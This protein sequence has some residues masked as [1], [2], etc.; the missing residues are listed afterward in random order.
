MGAAGNDRERLHR[1]I[2]DLHG[3]DSRW[4]E[5]VPVTETFEGQTIWD[6]VVQVF[7]LIDHP[8]ATRAYAWS[9]LWDH[10]TRIAAGLPDREP[11][12]SNIR[13]PKR[14]VGEWVRLRLRLVR[15][16]PRG[17]VTCPL[18]TGPDPVRGSR[19]RGEAVWRGSGTRREAEGPRAQGDPV[20]LTCPR[21]LYQSLS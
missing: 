8:T 2:R 21:S 1:A 7:D 18:R 20:A 16:M 14:P 10:K 12:R 15:P 6:G 17:H 13:A 9:H 5:A 19:P 3:C 4:I 11:E